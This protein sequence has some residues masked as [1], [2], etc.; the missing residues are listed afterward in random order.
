MLKKTSADRVPS[1]K[2]SI[3]APAIEMS[4][5]DIIIPVHK[6]ERLFPPA[7]AISAQTSKTANIK[8]NPHRQTSC[9]DL[10]SLRII[11]EGMMPARNGKTINHTMTEAAASGVIFIN[12]IIT[13]I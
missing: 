9:P 4:D 3:T 10:F 2:A 5:I 12:R 13:Y 1:P 11:I 6:K 8:K 7:I